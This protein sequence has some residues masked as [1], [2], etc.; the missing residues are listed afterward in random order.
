MGKHGTFMIILF[1]GSLI[2][3]IAAQT[4]SGKIKP[5]GAFSIFSLTPGTSTPPVVQ[6]SNTPTPSSNNNNNGQEQQKK[7]EKVTPPEGFTVNQLS[8]YYKKVKIQSVYGSQYL[9]NV[10][11]FTLYADYGNKESI[12][13]TGWR[14]NSNREEILIPQAVADYSFYGSLYPSDIKVIAGDYVYAYGSHPPVGENFRLNKCIGYLNSNYD[15]NPSL[16]G[17]C[18]SV[19]NTAEISSFPGDCQSYIYSLSGSCRTPKA[20]DIN[21]FTAQIYNTCRTYIENT[22]NYGA[23]YKAHRSDPDF[24]SHE[25]RVWIGRQFAFDSQ[26][27]SIRLFDRNGLLVDVYKY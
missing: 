17:S 9:G 2:I 25:W 27:D 3:F 23:C 6:V 24:F 11:T 26:H 5:E 14:I 18:P 7:E 4:L 22:F 8:P 1:V 13:I 20:N 19:S 10:S 12:D 16:S 21:R 15:F